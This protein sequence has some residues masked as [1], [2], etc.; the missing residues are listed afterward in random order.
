MEFKIFGF[1]RLFR[2]SRKALKGMIDIKPPTFFLGKM[3]FFLG[4]FSF[5]KAKNSLGFN[6]MKFFCC[7]IRSVLVKPRTTLATKASRKECLHILSSKSYYVYILEW[8]GIPM[9]TILRQVFAIKDLPCF[10]F[11]FWMLSFKYIWSVLLELIP[12]L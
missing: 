2:N 9:I 12:M 8:L 4:A 7:F 3:R 10:F 1:D 11:T 5:F 6:E